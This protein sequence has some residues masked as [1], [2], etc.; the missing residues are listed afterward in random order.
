MDLHSDAFLFS[1]RRAIWSVMIYPRC[2]AI[3]DLTRAI[4]EAMKATKRLHDVGQSLRF[5]NMTRGLLALS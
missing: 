1:V 3:S 2:P 5:D 4:G